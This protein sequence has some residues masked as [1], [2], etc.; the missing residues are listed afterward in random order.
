MEF[1]F[2]KNDSNLLDLIS[3]RLPVSKG[4]QINNFFNPFFIKNVMIT[5][6]PCRK[7]KITQKFS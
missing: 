7:S 2:K 6:Y 3:F 4:L 5:F 1:V